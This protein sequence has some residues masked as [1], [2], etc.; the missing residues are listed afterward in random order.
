[1]RKSI[2]WVGTFRE[3]GTIWWLAV[4]L[5]N[6]LSELLYNWSKIGVLINF[7]GGGQQQQ[8]PSPSMVP[9][10]DSVQSFASSTSCTPH[11]SPVSP[12]LFIHCNNSTDATTAVTSLPTSQQQPDYHQLSVV[13]VPF[14]IHFQPI[15]IQSTVSANILSIQRLW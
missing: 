11:H 1:M 3:P 9:R 13:Q 7:V 15:W 10:S 6:R 2:A 8:S 12:P 14:P 4:T 5:T